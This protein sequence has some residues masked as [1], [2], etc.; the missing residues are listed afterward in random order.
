MGV[1]QSV[2][3]RKI[4]FNERHKITDK[5]KYMVKAKEY[6]IVD[7]EL[8]GFWVKVTPAG[9]SFYLV[10]SKPQGSRKSMRKVIGSTSLYKASEA[11]A[12]ARG[13]IQKIKQGIDPKS[14]VRRQYAEAQLLESAFEHYIKAKAE[15][16]KLGYYSIRNYRA[17]MRGFLK[18]L[19][20][21]QINSI[22]EDMCL[23]WYKRYSKKA[24]AQT[25]RAFRELHAVMKYHVEI[26]NIESNPC[27]L[28]KALGVRAKP[29][30][31]T[32]SLTTSEIGRL[33]FELPQFKK[34]RTS[35]ITQGNLWFFSILTGLRESS[36]YNLRWSQVKFRD[37]IEFSTTKNSESYVLPLTPL[38]N[39]I[40]EEQRK[41]VDA[42]QNPECEFVFPNVYFSG[43][44]VDPRKS[45]AKFYKM[46]GVDKVF[47][48][49]DIR[50][51]FS[52]IADLAG[53]SYTDVKHLMVHKKSDITEKYMQ[54]QQ[55]KA[56]NN[57]ETIAKLVASE[58]LIAF[59]LSEDG[60]E[61]AHAATVDI[62]RFVLFGK[63]KLTQH[64]HRED[65]DFLLEVSEEFYCSE[66]GE[67]KD[68]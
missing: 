61:V 62:L 38:L 6:F 12:I 37:Q 15:L 63:G 23:A 42:S 19:M 30:V 59:N 36:I 60:N 50:R 47:R 9:N 44:I 65:A 54:S 21:R 45:M 66:R 35:S 28:I 22:T 26:G 20:G 13:W 58:T 24:S 33:I 18:P 8:S 32:G 57:Y 46:A 29:K 34:I 68:W 4:S 1:K 51:A 25:D 43:P 64:P 27:R 7:T 55:I 56:R 31:R 3:G 16:G 67:M 17:D 5:L 40:F 39:D 11:R 52:S 41:T 48:D 53:V 14:E 49:H 10:N 2:S